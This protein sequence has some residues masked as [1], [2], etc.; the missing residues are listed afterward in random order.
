[1]IQR[2]ERK[3]CK[4]EGEE[5]AEVEVEEGSEVEEEVEEEMEEEVEEEAAAIPENVN[6]I[7]L[8]KS[9]PEAK[10]MLTS[11]LF[12]HFTPLLHLNFSSFVPD[13]W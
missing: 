8:L 5:A 12:L 13:T 10:V 11:S 4:E 2:K 3:R 1:M 7:F 9:S 6:R